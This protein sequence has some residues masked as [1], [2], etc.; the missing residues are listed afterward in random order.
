MLLQSH[1]IYWGSPTFT[2]F[3]PSPGTHMISALPTA[4]HPDRYMNNT[5]AQSKHSYSFCLLLQAED[6]ARR[7]V[8][9]SE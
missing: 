3:H 1:F 7:L 8:L 4:L 6:A 5:Q 2:K 9:K